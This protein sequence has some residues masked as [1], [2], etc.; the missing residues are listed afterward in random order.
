MFRPTLFGRTHKVKTAFNGPILPS[1]LGGLQLWL[2]ADLGLT[3]GT[4][5]IIATGTTP[6][7]VTLTGTPN[8]VYSFEIDITTL[9]VRGV[10]VFKWS[11]DGG[12]TYT[13]GVLTAATVVLGSTGVTANFPTG[14]YAAD[15]VYT[16]FSTVIQWNDQSGTGDT[17]KNMLVGTNVA[18]KAIKSDVSLN[19][20]PAINFLDRAS[21]LQSGNWIS[22][23]P[24][25]STIYVVGYQA[26][27][28]VGIGIDGTTTGQR[29]YI[30]VSASTSASAGTSGSAD[31][32]AST[33]TDTSHPHIY[34]CNFDSTG[35]LFVDNSQ[36]AGDSESLTTKNPTGV[37]IGGHATLTNLS[38]AGNIGEALI[39]SGSHSSLQ[40]QELF[41]Y[42]GSRY[43]INVS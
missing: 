3:Y 37:T 41:K 38:W 7:A 23:V 36:V 34:C 21:K 33:G 43:A 32:T 13:T 29:Q 5:P 35:K 11:S 19:N 26:A 42:L 40:R 9:G 12:S 15:N 25:P 31:L 28:I 39:Y 4:S 10:A 24:F 18:P 2:R 27:P 20:R 14:T 1:D 8:D 6:P 17:N 16:S 22:V 30:Y